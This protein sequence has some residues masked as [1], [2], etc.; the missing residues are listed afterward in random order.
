MGVTTRHSN[1]VG[2]IKWMKS[3]FCTYFAVTKSSFPVPDGILESD[4]GKTRNSFSTQAKFF[5]VWAENFPH[6]SRNSFGG[7]DVSVVSIR[8]GPSL[9]SFRSALGAICHEKLATLF[10]MRDHLMTIP[11]TM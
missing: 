4:P 2:T 5:S 1:R 3:G 10:S 8:A 11:D 7:L 6:L 9:G